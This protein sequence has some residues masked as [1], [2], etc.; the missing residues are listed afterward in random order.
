[1]GRSWRV[2]LSTSRQWQSRSVRGDPQESP[3]F[4]FVVRSLEELRV[5]KRKF[6][7][8]ERGLCMSED[9]MN[10][11]PYGV[12]HIPPPPPAMVLSVGSYRRHNDG[13][14]KPSEGLPIDERAAEIRA[15]LGFDASLR[16][17]RLSPSSTRMTNR[18]FY[19]YLEYAGTIEHAL[20]PSTFQSWVSEMARGTFAAATIN[21]MKSNCACL[22][23]E[24]GKQ[25]FVHRLV[26]EA[27]GQAVH[28]TLL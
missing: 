27:F 9:T 23:E 19:A 26:A 21:R 16:A 20:Y 1:M 24:A 5:G 15:H 22:L 7:C 18:D 14:I 17:H 12:T 10:L 28:K 11:V 6:S 13:W 25:G 4:R 2:S 8:N 3:C